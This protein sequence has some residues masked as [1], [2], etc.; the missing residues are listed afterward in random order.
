[1]IA[2]ANERCRLHIQE[3]SNITGVI[4][5]SILENRSLRRGVRNLK[6]IRNNHLPSEKKK[7]CK[8]PSSHKIFPQCPVSRS[9][10]KKIRE[11]LGAS[12][13]IDGAKSVEVSAHIA[14]SCQCLTSAVCVKI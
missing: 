4:R 7:C 10:K 6:Y 12:D 13:V 5:L 2:V 8:Y 11:G 3:V 14:S 1:M 9:E